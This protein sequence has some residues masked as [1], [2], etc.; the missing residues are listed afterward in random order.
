MPKI[1]DKTEF[2]LARLVRLTLESG[3]AKDI[4]ELKRKMILFEYVGATQ[5]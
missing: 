1:K 4:G 3:T 2:T 5:H